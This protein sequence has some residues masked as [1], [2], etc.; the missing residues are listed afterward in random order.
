MTAPSRS[1]P[2]PLLEEIEARILYSADA[3]AAV[4]ALAPVLA[5]EQRSIES[6]GEFTS[7]ATSPAAQAAGIEAQTHELVFVDASLPDANALI[8]DIARQQTPRRQVETVLIDPDADGI[9]VITGTLAQRHDVGA[10]HI[11]GHGS[12][13]EVQLGSTRLDFDSML[14]NATRIRGWGDSLS[15]DADVLIYGCDVAHSDAGRALIDALSRLT[16]ADVAASDDPTGAQRLGGD[17]NLEY[18]A[19]DV[20]TALVVSLGEQD[21][22][23]GL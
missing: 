13:G 14:Q 5:V 3:V 11:L 23:E 7:P 17:W 21:L 22:W 20:Q 8:A 18:H 4:D 6:G 19:G 15:V 10:V 1:R 12:D 9:G 16:G 2:H